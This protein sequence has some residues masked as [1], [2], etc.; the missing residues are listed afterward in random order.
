MLY[1]LHRP[2]AE[3]LA[4]QID[5]SGVD[6]ILDLGGGSGVV[7]LALL[8][9][10]P[11]LRAVVVDLPGVCEAGREIAAEH[12]LEE[13]ID[14]HPADF[15]RD[16]L[17]RGFDLVL[18]CDVN[19]YTVGLFRKIKDTLL[20][21][22]RLVIVD[23]FAPA[24]GVAHPARTHWAFGGSLSRPEYS[25]PTVA[26]TKTQLI[27]AGFHLL[28]ERVLPPAPSP[29]TRFSTEMTLIEMVK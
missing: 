10:H 8:G 14:Y 16:E 27:E 1:E 24:D 29:S 26:G 17:P 20:P 15:L 25:P 21:G 6:R 12:S 3:E 5:V 9:L 2:L 28:A 7:P 18:E 11:G 23:Q 4:R 13:R 19:V 22:G